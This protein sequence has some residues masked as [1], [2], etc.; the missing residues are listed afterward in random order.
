VT[1]VQTCALPISLT[2]LRMPG[3]RPFVGTGIFRR[4]PVQTMDR[5]SNNWWCG[6]DDSELFGTDDASERPRLFDQIYA[7]GHITYPAFLKEGERTAA[8]EEWSRLLAGETGTPPLAKE[9]LDWAKAHPDDLRVP[10]SLHLAVRALR[11]G[12]SG[13]GSSKISKEAFDLLHRRY[14]KSEWTKKTPYWF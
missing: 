7:R 2:I 8:K 3:L 10:E 9:A 13:K 6:L 1:G 14:P 11:Y 5:Y 12:C 4:E